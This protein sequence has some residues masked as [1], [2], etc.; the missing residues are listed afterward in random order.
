MKDKSNENLLKYSLNS[1]WQF[2]VVIL[3]YLVGA[4][5]FPISIFTF[6]IKDYSAA[7]LVGTFLARLIC[8]AL[9]IY[10]IFALKLKQ[11]LYLKG[12]FNRFLLIIPFVLVAANNFPFISIYLKDAA[13]IASSWH[14]WLF[15][16]LAIFGGVLLEEL[17]FRGLV[18]PT[19]YRKFKSEKHGVFFSVLYSSLLFGGAHLFNLLSGAGIGAVVMQVGYSFLIGG[20]CAIA[21]VKTGS[22][23]NAVI[24]HFIFNFGGML[25]NYK[26]L[27]GSIWDLTTIIITAVLAVLV[28]VYAVYI[29]F[30][31]NNCE[32]DE[33]ILLNGAHESG[34]ANK[35]N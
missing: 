26:M 4:V 21:F 14:E 22:F 23:Y 7:N 13:F 18:L 35:E 32:F 17:T 20:M 28:I 11:I 5:G 24:L 27:T 10:L 3:M 19:L 9:P 30:K 8:C 33:K 2:V 16:A 1:P 15:Y 6:L 31:T 25:L 29:L 34:C 12:F